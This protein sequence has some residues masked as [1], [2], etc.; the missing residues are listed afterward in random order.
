MIRNIVEALAFLISGFISEVRGLRSVWRKGMGSD[1]KV[2]PDVSIDSV[3]EDRPTYVGVKDN[4]HVFIAHPDCK[5]NDVSVK[6]SVDKDL[7]YLTK[8]ND[9]G[10]YVNAGL[11]VLK[12]EPNLISKY[13]AR[14]SKGK[15]KLSLMMNH[16]DPKRLIR[17]DGDMDDIYEK[18][19]LKSS[20]GIDIGMNHQFITTKF[21]S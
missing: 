15:T 5:Y 19:E 10:M 8:K 7:D 9:I 11:D 12:D 13:Y 3:L 20:V 14:S 1:N 2:S 16:V 6:D 21:G 4:K 17:K 18:F